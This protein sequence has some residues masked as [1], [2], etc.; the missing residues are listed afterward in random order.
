M[1]SLVTFGLL[2]GV[3]VLT[4]ALAGEVVVSHISG[5]QRLPAIAFSVPKDVEAQ[6]IKLHG[7]EMA[8]KLIADMVKNYEQMKEQAFFNVLIDN[9]DL[10]RRATQVELFVE[11]LDRSGRK[12][13][14]KRITLEEGIEPNDTL[15]FTL[16][17][18]DDPCQNSYQLLAKVA[19]VKLVEVPVGAADEIAFEWNHRR[20]F[21]ENRWTNERQVTL[22]S[23]S[24]M[25]YKKTP[26]DNRLFPAGEIKADETRYYRVAKEAIPA[27]R[28]DGEIAYNTPVPG[29]EVEGGK[30]RK[31]SFF[32]MSSLG[33]A[34]T[35]ASGSIGVG[36]YVQFRE[37]QTDKKGIT[38]LI[39]P[40]CGTVPGH[41]S[42]RTRVRFVFDKKVIEG[43]D[44]EVIEQAVREWFEPVSVAQ[45]ASTCGPKSGIPVRV[46][47][48]RTTLE[49]VETALGPAGIQSPTPAG[50]VLVF[51]TLKMTFRDGRLS[52]VEK[53]KE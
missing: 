46:W 7:E 11:F 50:E 40:V 29:F 51:G 3:F 42:L 53:R 31:P 25:A 45:V 39:G 1:T 8:K 13:G 30:K 27:G 18:T 47:G 2:M 49:D 12:L 43:P 17:C 24:R 23:F 15:N 36:E 26:F 48:D 34:S 9:T 41:R 52:K 37:V 20:W 14:E 16:R 22:R 32:S 35:G 44:R 28:F 5:R 4:N 19:R 21:L 10:V 6:M 38:V 33:I